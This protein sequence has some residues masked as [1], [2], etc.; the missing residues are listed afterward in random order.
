MFELDKLRC[1]FN[2]FV[3]FLGKFFNVRV[4]NII[5]FFN[6]LKGVFCFFSYFFSCVKLLGFFNFVKVFILFNFVLFKL[7]I[8]LIV[9]VV[10]LWLIFVFLLLIC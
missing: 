9:V 6:F 3:I 4:F 7:V 1:N 8:I 5:F 2:I 10:N